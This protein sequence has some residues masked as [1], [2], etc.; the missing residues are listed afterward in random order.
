MPFGIDDLAAILASWAFKQVVKSVVKGFIHRQALKT[1]K[2][3]YNQ[4]ED[5]RRRPGP[6]MRKMIEAMENNDMSLARHY[7]RKVADEALADSDLSKYI[8]S[9]TWDFLAGAAECL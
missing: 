1:L 4:L 7:A 2:K 6:M 5:K 8:D 3:N 9:S